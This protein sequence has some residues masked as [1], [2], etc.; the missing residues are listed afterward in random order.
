MRKDARAVR[1]P[2]RQGLATGYARAQECAILPSV[3]QAPQ[4]LDLPLSARRICASWISRRIP[5]KQ[6]R[7]RTLGEVDTAEKAKSCGDRT[8]EG[9]PDGLVVPALSS[10]WPVGAPSALTATAHHTPTLYVLDEPTTG[11]HVSDVAR[12][13]GTFEKLVARGD[14][15]VVIEHQPGLGRRAWPRSGRSGRADRVRGGDAGLCDL[16]RCPHP[17]AASSAPTDGFAGAGIGLPQATP[18][19]FKAPTRAGGSVRESQCPGHSVN[20][21]SRS[22]LPRTRR[23]RV[24]HAS[25][26]ASL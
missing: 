26:Y 15:L 5:G 22:G 12:L 13:V 19:R 17:C 1:V 16:T 4:A 3:A 9:K 6:I 10:P 23:P 20:V 14:T 24:A 21:G 25:E 2:C 8:T 7:E 11:L 18:I